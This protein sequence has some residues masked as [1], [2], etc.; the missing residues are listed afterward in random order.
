MDIFRKEHRELS[1]TILRFAIGSMF[2][3]F[4]LDKVTDPVSW[5]ARLPAFLAVILPGQFS[6]WIVINGVLEMATGI[7]LV[8]G[9]YIR[10]A[11]AAAFLFLLAYFLPVGPDDI[12]VRDAGLMGACLSLF[13]YANNHAKRQV[14]RRALVIVSAFYIFF[15][16]VTGLLYLRSPA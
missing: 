8:T 9:W 15:L 7:A 2:L 16:F 14:P 11:S 1:T 6:V 12:T 4:G 3:W 10:E 5:Y 13:I